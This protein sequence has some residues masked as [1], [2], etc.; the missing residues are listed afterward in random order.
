MYILFIKTY[1]V[2]IL[3]KNREIIIITM[4]S[5]N[6]VIMKNKPNENQTKEEINQWCQ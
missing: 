1:T 6:V 4:L 3:S 2:Q 5:K